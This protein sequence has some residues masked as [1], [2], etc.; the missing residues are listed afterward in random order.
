MQ[1]KQIDCTPVF[2]AN[3]E[4]IRSRKYRAIANQGSTRSSKTYS[5]CQLLPSIAQDP[6]SFFPDLNKIGVT[7][8]SPSLP[9]LKRGAR[10]DFLEIMNNW[11]IYS[12]DNFNKTDN[13]YNFLALIIAVGLA[14]QGEICYTSTKPI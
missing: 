1:G 7:V 6:T 13:I 9:H 4:A 11:G 12:D 3:E 10:R 2:W 14:D 8:V 5:I